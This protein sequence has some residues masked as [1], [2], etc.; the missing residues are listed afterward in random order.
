[1]KVFR[2]C[3]VT[4]ILIQGAC[5]CCFAGEAAAARK[6]GIIPDIK[7]EEFERVKEFIIK[8]GLFPVSDIYKLAQ[9]Q[10]FE[11]PAAVTMRYTDEELPPLRVKEESLAMYGI[12]PASSLSPILKLGNQVVNKRKNE[13]SAEV[14]IAP[15][16]IAILGRAEPVIIPPKA[17]TTPPR[18]Y[19]AFTIPGSNNIYSASS[20]III[21]PYDPVIPGYVTS[22]IDKIWYSVDRKGGA[23][24]TQLYTKPFQLAEGKHTLYYRGV[25]KAGNFEVLNSSPVYIDGTAPRT[26]VS[27]KGEGRVEGGSVYVVSGSSLALAA[28]DPESKGI[29]STIGMVMF[30]VG[31][32]DCSELTSSHWSRKPGICP[33]YMYTGPVALP[34]GTHTFYYASMDWAGNMEKLNKVSVTVGARKLVR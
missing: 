28:V 2:I 4:L 1:M 21:D 18:T 32:K 13:I 26:T 7:G 6:T 33:A 20:L 31:E 19:A 3:F 34:D 30:T 23:L 5:P 16:Y 25:D 10:V 11:I 27:V 9:G 8:K 12:T 14:A 17:D 22:G 24:G 29:S 15:Q